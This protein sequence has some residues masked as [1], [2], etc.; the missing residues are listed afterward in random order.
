MAAIFSL[1]F[2]DSLFL[3]FVHGASDGLRLFPF[4][5]ILYGFSVVPESFTFNLKGEV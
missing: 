4:Y 2:F 1:V 5:L 3:G